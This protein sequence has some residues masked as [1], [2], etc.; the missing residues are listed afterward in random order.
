MKK[1]LQ[2]FSEEPELFNAGQV[3]VA[4]MSLQRANTLQPKSRLLCSLFPS[5][6]SRK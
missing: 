5:P 4:A 3:S 6:L 2:Q 1:C